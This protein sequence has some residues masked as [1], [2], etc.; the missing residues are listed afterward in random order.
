MIL[1]RKEFHNRWTFRNFNVIHAEE[2]DIPI[3]PLIKEIKADASHR[4]H[5]YLFNNSDLTT[6]EC[7]DEI[8]VNKYCHHTVKTE[9]ERIAVID[10][11]IKTNTY[12]PVK[13]FQDSEHTEIFIVDDGFHRIYSAWKQNK[14]TIRCEVKKGHF[15]LEKTMP[16]NDLP[17]LLDMLSKLF[18]KLHNIKKL[19]AF[20][21]NANTKKMGIT[22]IGY[23]GADK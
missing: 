22:S 19:T 10:Q 11:Q 6:V 13:L 5:E 14:K 3:E 2:K 21:K 15:K 8:G 1:T 12:T 9:A 7:D 4:N 18:P 16:M 23:G 20:L 17:D